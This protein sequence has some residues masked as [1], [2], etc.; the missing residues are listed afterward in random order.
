MALLPASPTYKR[1]SF[2][3]HPTGRL[4]VLVGTT[5]LSG[6]VSV[7]LDGEVPLGQCYP[8]ARTIVVELLA[9]SLFL[10]I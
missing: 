3:E 2:L 5:Y 8:L 7:V 1:A 9:G 4:Q 6:N 10:F